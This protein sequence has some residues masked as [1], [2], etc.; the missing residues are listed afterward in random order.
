MDMTNSVES[1]VRIEEVTFCKYKLF[2]INKEINLTFPQLLQLRQ[3]VKDL[4][5]PAK[6]YEIIE[7]EN[8]VLLFVA[9]KQHLI[10]L[11]IPQLLE[12][13]DE[14]EYFFSSF[15]SVLI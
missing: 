7:S 8:F 1:T 6:I 9:D 5:H 4:T 14:V 11:N 15:K 13:K 12:L 2:T 3:R 10:F